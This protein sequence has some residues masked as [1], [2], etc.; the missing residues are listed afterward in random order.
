ME[1]GGSELDIQMIGAG[2][3]GLLY[4]GKLAASGAKVTLWC[5]S[6][7]QAAAI[8]S[9][10][11]TIHH[12]DGGELHIPPG[13]VQAHPLSEFHEEAG[14]AADYLVLMVKQQGIEDLVERV[15]IPYG[16]SIQRCVCFQNGTGHLELLQQHLPSGAIYAAITTEGAKRIGPREV[17]HAGSGTTTIGPYNTEGMPESGQKSA[18]REISDIRL[19]ELLNRAG[20]KTYLSN[21][22]Y[23]AIYRKLMINAVINPL[24]ALWRIPNGALLEDP[25]RIQLMKELFDEACAVY[26]AAGISREDHLW[27]QIVGVCRMTS[28][29]TSSMLKDVLEGRATEISWINGSI[30]RLGQRHGVAA[31]KHELLCRLIEGTTK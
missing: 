26:D 19:I 15:F 9:S 14:A 5:R 21:E 22:I 25:M 11:I 17:L 18:S 12:S 4:A 7:E 29:N 13:V 28:T 1:N 10:G 8:H 24:T 6:D 16:R 23:T 20:F 31:P 2:S 27:D 3:L 30:V